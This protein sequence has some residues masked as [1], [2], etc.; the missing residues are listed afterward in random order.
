MPWIRGFEWDEENLSH[1]A[2]HGA[3]PE[4][5]EEA[6][7]GAPVVFRG[8]DGRYLAH[9]QTERGRLLFVVYVSRPRSVF[10]A[11]S[12]FWEPDERFN[13]ERRFLRRTSVAVR[14]WWRVSGL[15][16]LLAFETGRNPPLDQL[17]ARHALAA[18]DGSYCRELVR[19]EPDSHRIARRH[20]IGGLGP[21]A[22]LR[23]RAFADVLAKRGQDPDRY[24]LEVGKVGR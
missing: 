14:K 8:R 1:I 20:F 16:G 15:A 7:T 3:T 10:S 6:L 17:F 24:F 2:K 9:G 18:R 23:L 12:R 5:V 11:V 4:E 19:G 21:S 13:R 22:P